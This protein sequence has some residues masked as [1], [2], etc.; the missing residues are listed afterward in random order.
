MEQQDVAR[1]VEVIDPEQLLDPGDALLGER[2]GAQLFVDRVV[3]LELEARDHAIDDVVGVGR[4]LGGAR[5]DQRRARLVDQNRI[6]LVDDREVV[7]ALDVILQVELH[8]VAQV[9]EAEFV[10]LAVGDIG[11]VGG[12]ALLIG[13]AVDDHADAEAQEV[14][15]APHPFGVAPG[16]VIVDRDDVDAAAGRAR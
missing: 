8:V 4:F 9:V 13:Q 10:V 14:I 1:V 11:A 3:L 16:E 15:D 5:D 7:F 12:L 6:D 2:R